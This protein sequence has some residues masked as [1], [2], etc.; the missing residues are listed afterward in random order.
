MNEENSN[1]II[2]FLLQ[3]IE[4]LS[5]AILTDSYDPEELHEIHQQAGIHLYD[6]K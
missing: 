2:V 4:K 5:L 1:E 6:F 3:A